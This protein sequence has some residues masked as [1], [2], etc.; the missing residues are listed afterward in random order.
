MRIKVKKHFQMRSIAETV[1]FMDLLSIK[2]VQVQTEIE[3]E[4]RFLKKVNTKY[5]TG[6]FC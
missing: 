1:R 3:L 5:D 2:R 4:V 6:R